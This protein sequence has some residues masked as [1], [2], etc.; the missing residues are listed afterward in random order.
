MVNLL[1]QMIQFQENENEKHIKS[2]VLL[3]SL[4]I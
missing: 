1:A 4:Q 3:K 2:L